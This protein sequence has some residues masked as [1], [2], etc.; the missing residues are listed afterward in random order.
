MKYLL[1]NGRSTED[2]LTYIKDVI[3]INMLLLPDEIPYFDGGSNELVTDILEQNLKSHVTDEV[4]KILNRISNI[5][6][7]I[8]VSLAD[9]KVLVGNINVKI[10]IDNII[11]TYE[12]KRFNKAGIN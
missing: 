1:S 6:P 3:L 9:V 12:I 10:K 5:N 4:N 8:I 2:V 11:E 7:N